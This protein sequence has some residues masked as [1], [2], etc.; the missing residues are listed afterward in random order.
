MVTTDSQQLDNPFWN[1]ACKTWQEPELQSLL[2]DLQKRH[3]CDVNLILLACWSGVLCFPFDCQLGDAV[4]ISQQWQSDFIR[5]I[6]ALRQKAHEISDKKLK[7][8]LLD[9]ELL[10]EQAEI[11]A[12]FALFE[13]SIRADQKSAPPDSKQQ[14]QHSIDNLHKLFSRLELEISA[15]EIAKILQH[16]LS[17]SDTDTLLHEAKRRLA[18]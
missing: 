6:R 9:A 8:K 2:L 7:K 14:C 3:A 15:S 1:Y 18:Q 10:A 16:A 12:L 13:S 4:E 17:F 11:A 5:P